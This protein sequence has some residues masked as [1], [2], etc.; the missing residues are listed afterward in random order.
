MTKGVT[1][2]PELYQMSLS[3]PDK[4]MAKNESNRC[5]CGTISA[6]V[7][8]RL[9][10]AVVWHSLWQL[11]TFHGARTVREWG[12][13]EREGDGGREEGWESRQ[14]LTTEWGVWL[15]A[16]KVYAL[17][18]FGTAR[19]LPIHPSS[20]GDVWWRS[21]LSVEWNNTRGFTQP[22]WMIQPSDITQ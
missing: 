6:C 12:E 10:Y 4:K 9:L 14:K 18:C 17:V 8:S 22:G 16:E 7:F 11:W 21:G 13:R 19:F 1:Q 5:V 3:F 2:G 15:W 20:P